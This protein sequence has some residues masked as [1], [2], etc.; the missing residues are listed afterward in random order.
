MNDGNPW[1]RRLRDVVG[2]PPD[3]NQWPAELRHLPADLEA[4]SLTVP[5]TLPLLAGART[6]LQRHGSRVLI[7]L[8][9]PVGAGKSTLA[10]QLLRLG[11]RFGLTVAV[12]SIDDFYLPLPERRRV[13]AGNPVGVSR[14]PPGRHADGLLLET[15]ATWRQRGHLRLPRFN[16]TLAGG[17]GERDGW[18]ESD[19]DVLVLEGW[20]I[21]CR[22]LPGTELDRVLHRGEPSDHQAPRGESDRGVSSSPRQNRGHN[23]GQDLRNRGRSDSGLQLREEEKAWLPRW[24]SFLQAY[25]PLWNQLDGLWLLRPTRW[26]LPGRWRLQA[27]AR[28][29]RT[30]GGWLS[31]R[32]IEALVRSSLAS[33]P[34]ELYQDPL[35]TAAGFPQVAREENSVDTTA[36]GRAFSAMSTGSTVTMTSLENTTSPENTT[37]LEDTT[38]L[39]N[40]TGLEDSTDFA[41]RSGW[42]DTAGLA[43]KPDLAEAAEKQHAVALLDGQRRCRW[44]GLTTD[45]PF[46]A[47]AADQLSAESASSATG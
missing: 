17:E 12:A 28:Q 25:E 43:E 5:F 4:S 40:S 47:A 19:A 42:A 34:P 6:S 27:E 37:G 20:L 24:N 3:Q 33:L 41:D 38:D 46:S 16:K 31:A 23:G 22:S 29:R 9:G 8:N 32:D 1:Q 39:E 26:T 36:A 21:G 44:C 30:G 18:Q 2:L 15:I 13:L 45:W 10:R 7:G 14:G 35:L 11:P